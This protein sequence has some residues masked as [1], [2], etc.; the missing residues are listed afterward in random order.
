MQK[1]YDVLLKVGKILNLIVH[2]CHA[3]FFFTLIPIGGMIVTNKIKKAYANGEA[4]SIGLCI[5]AAIM[6]GGGILG[7][8]SAGIG[9]ACSIIGK[10]LAANTEEVEEYEEIVEE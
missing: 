5:A 8:P 6:A 3:V 10:K 9:I 2:I 7:W 1:A 4:P